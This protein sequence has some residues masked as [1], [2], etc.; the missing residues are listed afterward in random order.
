LTASTPEQHSP[1]RRRSAHRGPPPL[2]TQGEREGAW[3]AN[4]KEKGGILLFQLTPYRERTGIKWGDRHA[5][6]HPPLVSRIFRSEYYTPGPRHARV[7]DGCSFPTGT[8]SPTRRRTSSRGRPSGAWHSQ[9]TLPPSH[10]PTGQ[11]RGGQTQYAG[12]TAS[13]SQN[14][15]PPHCHDTRPTANHP[16]DPLTTPPAAPRRGEGHKSYQQKP[17]TRRSAGVGSPQR[18]A[19]RPASLLPT[20]QQVIGTPAASH[21]H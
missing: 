12:R 19:S 3:I 5:G 8:R 11:A 6:P 15:K 18:W 9:R 21:Q 20:R 7:A 2:P 1:Q 17:L 13:R 10:A 16:Q 14:P 4:R